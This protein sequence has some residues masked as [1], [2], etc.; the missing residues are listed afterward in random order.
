MFFCSP[1]GR[2]WV[3]LVHFDEAKPRSWNKCHF[4]IKDQRVK[5]MQTLFPLPGGEFLFTFFITNTAEKVASTS[6]RATALLMF[7]GHKSARPPGCCVST[8]TGAGADKHLWLPARVICMEANAE[9]THSH[10]RIKPYVSRVLC[11]VLRHFF[12]LAV[13]PPVFYM[14]D[15]SNQTTGIKKE[16]P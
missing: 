13:R 3:R 16:K 12:P 2:R 14:F 15:L 6:A 9:R 4:H 11:L 7:D 8:T 1:E 10:Q 5:C